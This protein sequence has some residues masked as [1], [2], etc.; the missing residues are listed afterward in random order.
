MTTETND[1]RELTADE[2]LEI[3]GGQVDP[4]TATAIRD[5]A[6]VGALIEGVVS[7]FKWMVPG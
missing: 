2:L 3:S 6:I 4:G 5:A 1:I 7:A